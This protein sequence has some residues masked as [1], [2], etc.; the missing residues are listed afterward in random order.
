M[1]ITVDVSGM[2]NLKDGLGSLADR[3]R[4]AVKAE[5]YQLAEEVMTA[6]KEVVPV[7]TGVLMSTGHVELPEE[8]FGGGIS[9]SL[10]YG[11]PAAPYAMQVHEDLD[12]HVHWHRPGS[13]PKYLENPLLQ[14]EPDISDRL[15]GAI[16]DELSK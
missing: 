13:G 3:I 5:L 11:G 7:D 4:Q 8:E 1:S 12:P 6:S 9:V 14:K 16:Q 2:G 10:G 15:A